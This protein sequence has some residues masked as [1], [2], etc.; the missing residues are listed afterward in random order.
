[1][2]LPSRMTIGQVLETTMGKYGALSGQ[3]IDATPFDDQY[4]VDNFG[5]L[6][7]QMGFCPSGKEVMYDGITG[8]KIKSKIFIGPTFYQRLK[9][10]VSDK[11]HAR[12]EGPINLLTHQPKVCFFFIFRNI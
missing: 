9:H 7:F 2:C 11:I 3:Y 6:L 4:N 1:M 8:Q 5:N 12:A 10:L